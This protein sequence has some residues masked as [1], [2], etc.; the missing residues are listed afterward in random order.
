MRPC[1]LRGRGLLTVLVERFRQVLRDVVGAAPLDL[2]TLQHV[3]ELSILEQR[4]LGRARSV[5]GEITPR[6]LH[7]VDILA[8][9]HGRER[10]WPGVVLDRLCYRRPCVPR[11]AAAHRIDDYESRALGIL[12][13]R[14]DF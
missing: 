4:D 2:M 14:V 13:P 11:G 9:E 7:C 3:D 10:A 6:S 1:R 5:A 8:G 12:E